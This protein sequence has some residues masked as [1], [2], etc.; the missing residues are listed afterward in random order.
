MK[1]A[2][3]AI[4]GSAIIGYFF[5]CINISYIL[6]RLNGF[7]IRKYGS[8]NAGASN[9]V[10][11]MG[12]KAGLFA[13]LF[14][15][16]K[17]YLAVVIAREFFHNA[18]VGGVN[19]ASLIAGVGSIIGHIAPFYMG[20]KGG[21]GLASLGGTIL[22]VDSRMFVI[23]L[24]LAIVIAVVTDYICFV[25][26]SVVVIFP[27]MDSYI[28]KSAWPIL[29]FLPAIMLIW[30]RHKENFVRIRQG[31]ELRFHFLWNRE[32]E[33][34]RLGVADDGREVFEHEVDK[35]NY[36]ITNNFKS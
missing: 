36:N 5:G 19:Y 23:L 34:E 24:V 25:P 9:V 1:Y 29:I 28:N 26:V 12:K 27:L 4:I 20:F 6:S 10:I 32:S 16:F 31:K 8:G 35:K 17:A 11:V 2:V 30:Y 7:D 33:S 21:K 3:F 18:M 13:A 22:A 14:D 15:I